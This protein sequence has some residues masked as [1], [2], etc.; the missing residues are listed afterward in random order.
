MSV[1]TLV[2]TVKGAWVLRSDDA[3]S[4]FDVDGPFFKGWKVTASMRLADGRYVVAT[5]S[6]V[7]GCAVHLSDDLREFRQL[8][9][10]P[11]WPADSGRKLNQIWKLAQSGS[12][13]WAGVDDAGLFRSTDEGQTWES[14]ASLNDRPSRVSWHPGFGGLCL[15]SIIPDPNAAD[16]LWVGISAVGVFRTDDAGA[17]WTPCNDGI[18]VILEDKEHKECGFCVHGLAADPTD[19]SIMWRQDHVGMF[20]SRDAG[21]HWERCETGLPSGFGFPIDIDPRTRTLFAVPL[22]A[23][24]FRFPVD[25]KLRVYR[26]TDGGDGWEATGD[27]LPDDFYG[28]VLRGAMAIDDRDP[29][30]VYIGTSAGTV[31]VSNDLG[32]SWRTIPVTLPRVVSVEAFSDA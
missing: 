5:A 14:I 17:T 19:P 16:R 26:T 13:W 24:Q 9:A 8:D 28:V 31:H 7:Y 32:A 25:G 22:E 2:G 4:A 29:A 10:A 23:D 6:D 20:R 1:T 3:R 21:A 15:H 12:T 27:G 18:P 30:G 11:S